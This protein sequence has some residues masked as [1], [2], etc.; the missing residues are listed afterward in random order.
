M[1]L[2]VGLRSPSKHETLT[3]CWFNVGPTS[4]RWA[5]TEPVL[6]Q[7]LVFAGAGP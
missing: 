6:D 3:S 2:G 7:R 5:N 1:G 4:K